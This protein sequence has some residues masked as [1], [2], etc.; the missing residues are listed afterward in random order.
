M[1]SASRDTEGQLCTMPFYIRNLSI[2]GF[3]YHQGLG[4]EDGGV[5]EPVPCRS[6]GMA[7]SLISIG[8]KTESPMIKPLLNPYLPKFFYLFLSIKPWNFWLLG[9][10]DVVHL[11]VNSQSTSWEKQL[12]SLQLLELSFHPTSLERI[13]DRKIESNLY[14]CLSFLSQALNLTYILQ[15]FADKLGKT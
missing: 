11:W 1:G 8:K 4:S 2:C 14:L 10:F 5:L 7:I 9:L 13:P 12:D 3:W 6:W 15:G